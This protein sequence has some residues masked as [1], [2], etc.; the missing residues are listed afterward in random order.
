MKPGIIYTKMTLLT[1]N[2]GAG[3][4]LIV[5]NFDTIHNM[6]SFIF[7]YLLIWRPLGYLLVFIGMIFEGDIFLFTTGFLTFQRF[8]DPGDMLAILLSGALVGDLLWFWV[9]QLLDDSDHWFSRWAIKLAKPFDSHLLKM[10]FRTILLS[11]FA[12]GLHHP[13][14]LRAG[15]LRLRFRDYVKFD[16]LATVLWVVAVGGLG[17]FSGAS[18]RVVRHYLKYTEFALLASLVIF[19][20]VWHFVSNRSKSKI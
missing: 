4:F 2:A 18:F 13:I 1:A 6:H 5:F 15:V 16:L 20:V 8:F 3:S 10:P 14:L 11:K 9:G 19:L 17:Y 7:H 12:Y